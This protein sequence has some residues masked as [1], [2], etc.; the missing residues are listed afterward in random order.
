MLEQLCAAVII[1]CFV[2]TTFVLFVGCLILFSQLQSDHHRY[3]GQS[4]LLLLIILRH[5]NH[6]PHY[7]QHYRWRSAFDVVDAN[8]TIA[9]F[10]FRQTRL[11]Q[12]RLFKGAGCPRTHH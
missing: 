10:N 8:L 3:L 2:A 6:P 5:C 1:P 7:Y 9:V 12:Q 11:N 4:P